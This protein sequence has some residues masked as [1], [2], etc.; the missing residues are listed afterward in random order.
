MP[1]LGLIESLR[2]ENVGNDWGENSEGSSWNWAGYSMVLS[3][4]D[5]PGDPGSFSSGFC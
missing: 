1:T 5:F 2:I 4:Y 3:C